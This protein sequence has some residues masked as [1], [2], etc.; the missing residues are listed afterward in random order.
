MNKAACLL[1]LFASTMLCGAGPVPQMGAQKPQQ[2]TFSPVTAEELVGLCK[3]V[4]ANA[5]SDAA[6]LCLTYISGF[7]DGYSVA[8]ARFNHEKQSA[9]CPPQEVTRQQMA[10]VLV[11]YGGDHPNQLWT[12]GALFTAIALKDAY[13]CQE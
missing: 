7:T 11:K 8:M 1:F 3:S 10:K 2:V 9:F 5:Q 12:G 13:P 4:D 6:A